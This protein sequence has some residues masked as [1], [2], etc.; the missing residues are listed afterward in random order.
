MVDA[1][2]DDWVPAS[3]S[4]LGTGAVGHTGVDDD[5]SY[6]NIL[7]E[8]EER[9]TRVAGRV[10][11][12]SG[13]GLADI[14]VWAVVR[15]QTPRVNE[16]SGPGTVVTPGG[17]ERPFGNEF[18]KNRKTDSAGHYEMAG[19]PAGA[20]AVAVSRTGTRVP[21]QRFTAVEGGALTA[22]FVLSD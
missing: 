19:L 9:G 4:V 11:S 20:L 7:V 5:A 22:D 3:S 10:T 8:L 1:L 15:V 17:E 2:P 18:R 16:G 13:R 21:A 14:L 6:R 12:A